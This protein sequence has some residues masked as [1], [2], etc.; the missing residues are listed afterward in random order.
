MEF[1]IDR[2]PA[3][4]RVERYDPVFEYGLDSLFTGFRPFLLLVRTIEMGNFFKYA[5]RDY[6]GAKG[7]LLSIIGPLVYLMLRPV[8]VLLSALIWGFGRRTRFYNLFCRQVWVV[9]QR[10]EEKEASGRAL[11]QNR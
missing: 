10:I 1:L 4:F 3:G 6:P 5:R 7:I 8:D 11:A 9:F 2:V